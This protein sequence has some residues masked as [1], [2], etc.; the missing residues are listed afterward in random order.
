MDEDERWQG[1]DY[2][3]TPDPDETE[4]GRYVLDSSPT[5]RVWLIP[6]TPECPRVDG[7]YVG[8]IWS[9]RN[10]PRYTNWL[11]GEDPDISRR[12]DEGWQKAY[13]GFET[14][15][16]YLRI[17]HGANVVLPLS[18]GEGR[19]RV[20]GEFITGVIFD[21]PERVATTGVD[22][23]RIPEA[24]EAEVRELD[25]W[26]A[27]DCW[28]YRIERLIPGSR[29]GGVSVNGADPK[30]CEVHMQPWGHPKGH[31]EEV[32]SCWG[33]VGE[34]YAVQEAM[35]AYLHFQSSAA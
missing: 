28:G 2:W 25:Q 9:A 8:S 11:R 30:C 21:T 18:V 5:L 23:Q 10:S 34:A 12:L 26:L 6:D 15:M 22:V 14:V 1:D 19:C 32:D 27:G 16:R 17:F 33:F 20:Q 4:D 7:C 24:L 29:C 35:A 13:W 31:W 3:A